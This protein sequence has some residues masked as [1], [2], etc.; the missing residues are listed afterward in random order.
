M[1]RLAP[2]LVWALLV[3]GCGRVTSGDAGPSG[4]VS[5]PASRSPTPVGATSTPASP[6]PA[7]SPSAFLVG[8][9]TFPSAGGSQTEPLSDN[10]K[11]I[12]AIPPGWARGTPPHDEAT[13]ATM[14]APSDYGNARTTIRVASEIGYHP[15]MTP[16]QVINQYY[17]QPGMGSVQSCSV[18]SDPAAFF[19]FTHGS[20]NGYYVLWLHFNYAYSVTLDSNGALDSRS[21]HDAKG[22]LASVTWTLA[23]PPPR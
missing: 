2:A 9:C 12:V 16:E 6:S 8:D 21:I 11:M 1:G 18:N 20:H 13:L 3:L 23:S 5:T 7:G 22:V 4:T 14:T 19:Q 15:N 10:F 17:P